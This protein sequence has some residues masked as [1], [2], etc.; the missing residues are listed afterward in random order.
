[1]ITPITTTF[2]A[3]NF[4]KE[5]DY[6]TQE[7]WAAFS[8]VAEL[9]YGILSGTWSDKSEE[10]KE[11]TNNLALEIQEI[12]E[13]AFNAI[14]LNTI[15][16]LA[17]YTGTG[18]VIV[19][20]INRGGNFVSKTAIEID[21]NTGSL[22]VAN[23]GTVFA[24]LGGGF[25]VRQYS[26]AVNVK[27]F[28]AV[29]DGI[30]NDLT[31]VQNALYYI[32][33]IQDISTSWYSDKVD[34]TL[35]FTDG[36]YLID[37]TLLTLGNVTIKGDGATIISNNNVSTPVFE[38]CY[39]DG[40]I[41]T[42]NAI[43]DTTTLLGDAVTNLKFESLTFRNISYVFKLRGSIWQSHISN[44]SF[45]Y[46]GVVATANNCF[47]F[48]YLDIMSYGT[49]GTEGDLVGKFQL[50]ESNNR[51]S[52][53]RVSIAHASSVGTENGIGIEIS[54]GGANVSV[55]NSSFEVVN[56]AIQFTGTFNDF[57]LESTYFENLNYIIYD[58]D[59][60]IKRGFNID[61]PSGYTVGDL[62][63]GS[64]YRNTIIKAYQDRQVGNE[65]HRGVVRLIAGTNGNRGTTVYMDSSYN[66]TINTAKYL[67]TSDVELIPCD[68]QLIHG[69]NA[70]GTYSKYP[71]GT[72]IQN[73]S[74]V[75]NYTAD[76]NVVIPLP[77][78]F[79]DTTYSASVSMIFYDSIDYLYSTSPA[80]VGTIYFR[81]G[82]TRTGNLLSI[83]AIGRWK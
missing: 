1:M 71:D 33:S 59:G 67:V 60:A 7:D 16:D 39:I 30:T 64:G 62:I 6:P 34:N 80:S 57:R 54:G 28:G 17:T 8:A 36:T 24:K 4:P 38:T 78:D 66:N 9:N 21:P 83:T 20:D 75:V 70:N 41:W 27:W 81:S 32:R 50:T 77:I 82:N 69:S 18:L 31:S 52:F 10:F 42:S 45:Y 19:K 14:S 46:C 40:G 37:G 55:T 44:C 61:V 79:K 29:G 74:K 56:K 2:P 58:T 25:W 5:V 68:Y 51:I 49:K 35:L 13:N 11:Q 47:Y 72:L 63:N 26:G 23:G 22:Y 76:T 65:Y 53:D 15:D 73:I 43:L 3:L 12:G 48:N